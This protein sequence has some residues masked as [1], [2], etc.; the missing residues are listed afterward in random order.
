ME[1][2]F[3]G[4]SGAPAGRTGVEALTEAVAEAVGEGNAVIYDQLRGDYG[5]F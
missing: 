2:S 5:D 4:W 1:T 3:V